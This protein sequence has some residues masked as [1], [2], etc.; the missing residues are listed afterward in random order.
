MKDGLVS[1]E[2]FITIIFIIYIINYNNKNIG[3]ILRI[4]LQ[5]K[6]KR[7]KNQFHL[8]QKSVFFV[9]MTK[10]N[11]NPS[12][13]KQR[14]IIIKNKNIASFAL[15]SASVNRYNCNKFRQN[16]FLLLQFSHSY[17]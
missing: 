13:L 6:N 10:I 17:Y 4:I 7:K 12:K 5:Q 2:V 16:V 8:Y 15:S 11:D 1:L 14:V 9:C 3:V